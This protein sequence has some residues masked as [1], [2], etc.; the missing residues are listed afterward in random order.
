LIPTS[1]TEIYTGAKPLGR[2]EAAPEAAAASVRTMFDAIAPRYDVL[3]HVLSGGIDLTW[4]WRTARVLKPI[5]ARPEARIVDLCCGTGDMALALLKRRPSTSS[6]E[7]ILA[8]DFSHKMLSLGRT[9]FIGKNI[10]PV[11]GDALH[12]PL[13]QGSA[14]LIS[15]A[16]G[17][18]NLVSYEDGLA[19][20]Y[21]VLKP[22][23]QIAILE[24]NQ[25]DGLVAVLYNLYFKRILP[26]I[27]G[28]LSDRTAYSYLPHSVERFPRSPRMLELIHNAGFE[29]A[30]WTSYTFGVSGLYRATKPLQTS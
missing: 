1:K 15:A 21:R 30:T 10:I 6:T 4:W 24:C 28:K 11:E 22:G 16:F 2:P 12:L 7:P 5:L 18:R 3:N 19:E 8:V 25:P 23:G 9:K 27:G 29:Q 26:W 20:L 17:F 13:Q 14:D